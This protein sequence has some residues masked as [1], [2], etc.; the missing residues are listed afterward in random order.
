MNLNNAKLLSE[1]AS[2]LL[3]LANTMNL[4]GFASEAKKLTEVS[5]VLLTQALN[6]TVP[7]EAPATVVTETK[8]VQ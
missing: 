2:S 7:L 5:Q 6:A 3:D 1:K 4:S 8:E